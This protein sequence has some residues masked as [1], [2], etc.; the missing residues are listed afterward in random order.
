M[1]TPFCCQVLLHFSQIKGRVCAWYLITFEDVQYNTGFSGCTV[2][3]NLP[4]NVGDAGDL[5]F[6]PGW[7]RFPWRRKW[8]PTP[9]FLPGKTHGQRNLV[10]YSPWGCKKSDMTGHN[11]SNNKSVTHYCF[12]PL[13]LDY[14][15]IKL[16]ISFYNQK[17]GCS[18]FQDRPRD[19]IRE[20]VLGGLIYL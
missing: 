10:G 18:E 15:L 6:F 14:K 11:N 19:T 16:R 8:Q 13:H 2:I 9:V 4:A 3:K 7:R 1:H 20:T 17:T 5:G 12:Y